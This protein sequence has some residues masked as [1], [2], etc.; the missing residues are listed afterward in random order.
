MGEPDP[1]AV[2]YYSRLGV[3]PT[4]DSET[5]ERRRKQADRR[6]SPMS[7]SPE[8]GEKRHMRINAA[9]TVLEDPPERDRYDACFD[10]FGRVTGTAVYET[11]STDVLEATVDDEVLGNHLEG[12]VEILGPVAGTR[13][14]E[15][16]YDELDPPIAEG[17]DVPALPNGYSVA[18]PGFG[19]AAWSYHEAGEPCAL[20]TWLTG[21]GDLW[22]TALESPRDVDDL[23]ADLSEHDPA[24]T[25]ERPVGDGARSSPSASASDGGT[26]T[27]RIDGHP[28]SGT[29]ELPREYTPTSE[30]EGRSLSLSLSVGSPVDRIGRSL[31]YVGSTTAWG[32]AST[33]VA[34]A[35]G[36]TGPVAAVV[37]FV[38]LLA[39]ALLALSAGGGLNASVQAALGVPLAS[40]EAPFRTPSLV[41]YLSLVVL[42]VVPAALTI[43]FAVPWV[44]ARKRRGLPR[45][46]WLVFLFALTALSTALFVGVGQ[47][48]LPRPVALVAT[49]LCSVATFQAARDVGAPR[50]LS[51]LCR[52]VA[53]VA[54]GLLSTVAALALAGVTLD[55][56]APGLATAYVDALAALPLVESPLVSARTA[57]LGVVAFGALSFVPLALTTLYSLSYA[58]ESAVLR[59]RSRAYG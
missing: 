21:G 47:G 42:A 58:V 32:L 2:D 22:R 6:F 57:E 31:S 17:E 25:P 27:T 13:A 23:V 36:V 26:P 49:A 48:R 5:I 24:A 28:S 19:V 41:H 53:A 20:S 45:D 56:V 59:L 7:T 34:A 44:D 18:D 51:L 54:V 3:D 12:F 50:L 38:P 40:S 14:Y 10:R 35:F 39:L 29:G 55:A 1:D 46:S 8:A 37:V 33:A 15:A 43:R 30:R 16:Y 52:S 11:L 4:A 9:S